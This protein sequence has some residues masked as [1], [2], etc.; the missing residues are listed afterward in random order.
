MKWNVVKARIIYE[1][2]IVTLIM[3]SFCSETMLTKEQWQARHHIECI[4][5]VTAHVN[6]LRELRNSFLTCS[7]QLERAESRLEGVETIISQL[8]K[9]HL[10]SSVRYG[11]LTG[12]LGLLE[13]KRSATL[14][15][16]FFLF[17]F[18][19]KLWARKLEQNY[20][21]KMLRNSWNEDVRFEWKPLPSWL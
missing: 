9:E 21:F 13:P 5:P 19:W 16:L 20:F 3:W 12:W 2:Y 6:Q 7:L 17:R 18:T 1:I 8:K 10:I 14:F 4:Y 15:L 11:M